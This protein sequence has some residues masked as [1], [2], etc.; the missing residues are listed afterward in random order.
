[1]GMYPP[2]WGPPTWD[3]LL[4]MALNFPETNA[5]AA[6]VQSVHDLI[7]S[8]AN[9]VPCPGCSSHGKEYVDAH[10]P[11]GL[12]TREK[13][14]AYVVDFHNHVNARMGKRQFTV[15]EAKDALILRYSNG[16]KDLPR[17]LQIRQEDQKKITALEEQFKL[18]SG[19][20]A[21]ASSETSPYAYVSIALGA[22]TLILIVV[23]IV[24][25]KKLKHKR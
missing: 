21:P 19:G 8:V 6:L 20:A 11:T 7:W 14:V 9:L 12:N 4:I 23:I 13:F 18:V 15:Q 25:A 3:S 16:F 5:S 2:V 10:K 22:L 24:L 17:A 1:M